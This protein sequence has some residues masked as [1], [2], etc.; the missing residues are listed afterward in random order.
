MGRPYVIFIAIMIWNLN[1]I[2]VTTFSEVSTYLM[3]CFTV[4]ILFMYVTNAECAI[5]GGSITFKF[6][7]LMHN[8]FSVYGN[9]L[10]R[11]MLDKMLHV[12]HYSYMIR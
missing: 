12:F 1:C 11:R 6:I 5:T 4:F 3:H 2:R 7:L 10:D 8:S 9:N